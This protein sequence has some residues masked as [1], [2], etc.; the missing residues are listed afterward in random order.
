MYNFTK[1]RF[2][3]GIKIPLYK[4]HTTKRKNYVF[5]MTTTACKRRDTGPHLSFPPPRAFTCRHCLQTWICRSVLLG[6]QT[7]T[8]PIKKFPSFTGPEGSLSR[9]EVPATG[10]YPKSHVSNP[11]PLNSIL[12]LH[13]LLR[14]VL[15]KCF[16]FRFSDKICVHLFCHACY[17]FQASH[18]HGKWWKL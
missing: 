1:L 16:R 5:S 6:K 3:A 11:D 10:P 14:L 7:A 17:M 15:P 4:I 12:I 2:K 9:S 13:F 18:P 8:Q